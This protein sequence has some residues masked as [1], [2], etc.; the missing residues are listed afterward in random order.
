MPRTVDSGFPGPANSSDRANRF[1]VT[2]LAILAA[3]K[4]WWLVVSAPGCTAS[5]AKQHVGSAGPVALTPATDVR[6]DSLTHWLAISQ[7]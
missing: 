1:Y 7:R 5:V 2:F 6:N 4:S 3:V